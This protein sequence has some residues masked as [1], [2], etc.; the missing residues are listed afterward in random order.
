MYAPATRTLR[1][2]SAGHPPGLLFEAGGAAP[3]QLGTP[4]FPI[5][6]APDAQY[7]SSTFTVVPDSRLY[8][9]ITR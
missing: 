1:Y 5:G 8:V 2:A 3:R 4:S 9:R 6:A 7:D